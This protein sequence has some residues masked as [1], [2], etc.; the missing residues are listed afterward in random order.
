MSTELDIW[1]MSALERQIA[2][3]DPHL[4]IMVYDDLNWPYPIPAGAAVT[5]LLPRTPPK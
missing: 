1:L 4:D 5:Q 3:E 2:A